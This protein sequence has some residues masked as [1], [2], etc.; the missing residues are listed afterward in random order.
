MSNR[1]C[2]RFKDTDGLDLGCH[3]VTKEHMLEAYPSLVPWMKAPALWVWGCGNRGA[4]GDNTSVPKSSPVQTI[5]GGTDWRSI[6]FS[7]GTNPTRAAI[8]TNGTLW[9][10]GAGN[11]G[12]MGDNTSVS[13]SSPVQTISG[14]ENWKSISLGFSNL[15][16]GTASAIKTDGTL[17]AW[18]SSGVGINPTGA[19]GNNSTI[20]RSSPVQTISAGTNWKSVSAGC[21][22]MAS[23]KT[24]GTLWVWGYGSR[25]AL[26]NNSSVS[27]SSPVQTI[28]GG[29]NWKS[30]SVGQGTIA[31]LKT[32]GTLWAWG[33][34]S[35]GQLGTNTT[36]SSSSPVQ[37]ISGGTNWKTLSDESSAIKT[38]GTLWLWGCN[39]SGA[40]GDNTTVNRSSPVQTVSGGANWKSIGR[41]LGFNTVAIKTDGTLWTWGDG[42]AGS[43]GDNST[44]NKSS[45]VQIISGGTGWRCAVPTM[46]IR[47]EGDY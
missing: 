28:S 32:D 22:N 21:S 40:I 44:I 26:G 43:I 39:A 46:A 33:C 35:V 17:W 16:Y 3:L 27:A 29:T 36:I 20:G 45:P 47:D 37:T 10:W 41:E 42:V 11:G 25:G 12:T 5:S 9:L 4:L 19:L 8:K 30:V 31:A 15:G 14:G 18:G 1:V 2:T 38:D 24:D 13:K 23:I 6:S 7:C 34:N